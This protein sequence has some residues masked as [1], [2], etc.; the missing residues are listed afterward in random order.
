MDVVRQMIG[1]HSVWL[2]QLP[3]CEINVK[4]NHILVINGRVYVLRT[5]NFDMQTLRVKCLK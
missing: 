5:Q 2:L 4:K 3:R 1:F